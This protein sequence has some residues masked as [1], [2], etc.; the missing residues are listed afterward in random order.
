MEWHDL[1]ILHAQFQIDMMASLLRHYQRESQRQ[2][3]IIGKLRRLVDT[4]RD[5]REFVLSRVNLW[6]SLQTHF[7]T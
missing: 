5:S 1:T 7:L 2:R 3:H 6:S 4:T